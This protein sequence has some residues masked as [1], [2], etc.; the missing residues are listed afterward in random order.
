MI[1]EKLQPCL[2]TEAQDQIHYL[3]GTPVWSIATLLRQGRCRLSK[4]VMCSI[5]DLGS[6]KTEFGQIGP[7]AAPAQQGEK[8]FRVSEVIPI[9]ETNPGA[10]DKML[11]RIREF[12]E[13]DERGEVSY[14]L[15]LMRCERDFV[16]KDGNKRA[17]AFYERRKVAA[18]PIELPVFVV[19]I[20]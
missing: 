1:V 6:L 7:F 8:K 4:G 11:A 3:E 15:T 9:L 17:I 12:I 19:E 16:V 18:D 2:V 14:N 5:A 13:K 20:I 10:D